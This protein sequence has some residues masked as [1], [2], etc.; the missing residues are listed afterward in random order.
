LIRKSKMAADL[1][2]KQNFNII[3][4]RAMVLV[5]IPVSVVKE[6]IKMINWIVKRLIDSKIQDDCKTRKKRKNRIHL[7]INCILKYEKK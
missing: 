6:F 7:F 4:T 3:Y 2:K 5:S 1:K